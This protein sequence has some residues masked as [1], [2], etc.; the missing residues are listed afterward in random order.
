MSWIDQICQVISFSYTFVTEKNQDFAELVYEN[1]LK[2][3]IFFFQSTRPEPSYDLYEPM[4]DGTENHNTIM[5][6]FVIDNL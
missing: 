2:R 5:Y 3:S 4:R 1:E 6:C